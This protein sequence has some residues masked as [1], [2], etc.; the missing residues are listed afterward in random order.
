MKF[1]QNAI[2][3]IFNHWQSSLFG[4]SYGV[5]TWLFFKHE[6]NT[7]EWMAAMGTLL[8]VKGIFVNKDPDKTA[9]KPDAKP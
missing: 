1:I 2:D 9:N 7:Q 3:R 8:T 5:V 6:I 4:I